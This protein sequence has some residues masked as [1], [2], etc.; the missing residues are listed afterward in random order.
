MVIWGVGGFIANV[1]V[2]IRVTRVMVI[3]GMGNFSA[4]CW[5][6]GLSKGELLDV[7]LAEFVDFERRES[8]VFRHRKI[9]S[10]S[11]AMR[12]ILRELRDLGGGGSFGNLTG[13]WSCRGGGW[14]FGIWLVG[15]WSLGCIM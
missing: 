8:W 3:L 7:V 12:S 5:T 11:A 13:F 1:G 10:R 15:V 2:G 14:L 9:R 4:I 6:R